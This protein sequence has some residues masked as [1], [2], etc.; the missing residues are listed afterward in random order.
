MDHAVSIPEEATKAAEFDASA[1][2]DGLI[3]QARGSFFEAEDGARLYAVPGMP[4]DRL[5]SIGYLSVGKR[6]RARLRYALFKPLGHAIGTLVI[7]QGRAEYVEKYADIIAR[8]VRLGFCVVAF[9]LRGQGLS[10]RILRSAPRKGHIHDFDAYV[11]D[12]ITL[13]EKVVLPDCPLPL[14]GLGHSLGGLIGLHVL[15]KQP[16]WFDRMI[17]SAPLLR[18]NVSSA[19]HET[20]ARAAKWASRFG[21]GQ[22]YAPGTGSTLA[23]TAAFKANPATS[24]E[25]RYTKTAAILEDHPQLG[26][27]GPTYGWLNQCARGMARMWDQSLLSRIST[28]TL[29]VQAGADEVVSPDAVE[30]LA[31]AV[32]TATMVRLPRSKHEPM[33]EADPIRDLFFA[34]SDAFLSVSEMREA[35]LSRSLE[36]LNVL[37]L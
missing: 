19:S 13:V 6:Q 27:G 7:I 32:P 4:M 29:F 17:L 3:H 25:A 22:A 20:I 14:S 9:D 8:Y 34:A 18:Y 23:G 33:F 10:T 37:L 31:A 5:H 30:R 21:F 15:V 12:T 36:N 28:P 2:P 16:L 26:L 1:P 24:D 11:R 35:R